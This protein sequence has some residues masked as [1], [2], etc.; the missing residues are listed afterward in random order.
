MVPGTQLNGDYV[1]IEDHEDRPH[2]PLCGR[3]REDINAVRPVKN[4]VDDSL[5]NVVKRRGLFGVASRGPIAC[6]C[7]AFC[8]GVCAAVVVG[9]ASGTVRGWEESW[10][11]GGF[12]VGRRSPG[13]YPST[14]SS[15]WP[16][17]THEVPVPAGC[18]SRSHE[19]G[20]GTP[21]S[22]CTNPHF[23]ERSGGLC[24]PFCPQNYSGVVDVCR[25]D[26]P[27][28]TR[29]VST[30]D[31]KSTGEDPRSMINIPAFT[32]NG[33]YCHKPYVG[34]WRGWGHFSKQ[35]CESRVSGENAATGECE[36]CF[37]FLFFP[38]CQ[39][40]FH[41]WGC[42]WC[43]VDCPEGMT[44]VGGS[45]A[46]RSE[47]RGLGRPLNCPKDQ[48][49][50]G[51]LCYPPCA[52]KEEERV[53]ELKTVGIG[54][55]CWENLCPAGGEVLFGPAGDHDEDLQQDAFAKGVY[56]RISISCENRNF[57]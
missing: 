46:K 36:R 12:P 21:P 39:D 41:A 30:S 26:C 3:S 48:E 5:L 23:P 50:S 9:S 6:A 51:A 4:A 28:A 7:F 25:Q 35:Y 53:S 11:L 34:Y 17:P 16:V 47:R 1:R 38:K 19:R 33:A 56:S 52:T 8:V 54:P 37:G 20:A 24:Y 57:C 42:N 43:S 49:Q 13:Q 18:W 15:P 31:R 32:N 22:V 29:I 40:G 10:V 2:D 44:D 55:V 45:C 27:G 14:G